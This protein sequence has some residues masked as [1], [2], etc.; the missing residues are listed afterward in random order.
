MHLE[1]FHAAKE[2]LERNHS[3]DVVAGYLSPCE[4]S[5]VQ[6]KVFNGFIP[7]THRYIHCKIS[8]NKLELNYVEGRSIRMTE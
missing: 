2:Y 5:Y 8:I 6:C 1:V 4:D 7:A 3:F